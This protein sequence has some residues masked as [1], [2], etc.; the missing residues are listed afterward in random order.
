VSGREKN[1]TWSRIRT[2]I[3]DQL[4]RRGV[5]DTTTILK[6]LSPDGLA[7]VKRKVEAL[8]RQMS[9]KLI[10]GRCIPGGTVN[11]DSRRQLHQSLRLV[12]GCAVMRKEK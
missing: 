7:N 6:Q 9:I 5:M 4:E 1:K 8:I 10:A 11:S 12:P 2:I 3:E